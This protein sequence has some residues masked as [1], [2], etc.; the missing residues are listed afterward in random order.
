VLWLKPNQGLVG[1]LAPSRA[2]RMS[3]F[4]LGLS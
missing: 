4:P 3:T 1:I 2:G